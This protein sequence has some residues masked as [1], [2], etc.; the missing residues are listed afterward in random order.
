[1]IW[2][3]KLVICLQKGINPG[4]YVQRTRGNVFN[5]QMCI[6]KRGVGSIFSSV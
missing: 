4:I 6:L 2:I 5:Q 1:M 3:L